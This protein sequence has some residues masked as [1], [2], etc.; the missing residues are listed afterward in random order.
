MRVLSSAAVAVAALGFLSLA[1]TDAKADLVL[2]GGTTTTAFQNLGAQGFGAAPRLLTEQQSP[3]ESGSVSG[4]GV[5]FGDAISGSNKSSAPTLGFVGWTSGS[6]V[7][8]GFNAG[9]S[10]QTALTLDTLVLTLWDPTGTIA[11][12]TFS[13]ASAVQFSAAVLALQTGN[14]NAVFE[15]V[16]DSTQA[17]QFTADITSSLD[18]ISLA[19]SL[20]CAGTP[21]ATCAVS[22]DGPD[23]FVAVLANGAVGNVPE[24]STWAMMILGFLGVGFMAYRRKSQG[25][26][27]LA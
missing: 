15:F 11:L 7:A 4:T 10:G 17:A 20:G 25:H 18:R 9:Q 8:I 16:L 6:N 26:F 21:S 3:F 19:S 2:F 13:L 14:G 23:S 1:P 12:G 27:R 24:P 5:V 22:N